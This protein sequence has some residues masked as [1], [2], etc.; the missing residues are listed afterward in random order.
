[1][2]FL[3]LS[4]IPDP[5]ERADFEQVYLDYSKACIN[6]ALRYTGKNQVLAEDALHNAVVKILSKHPE[7]LKDSC[8]KLKASIVLIVRNEAI[9]LMRKE[10]VR[11]HEDLDNYHET[12][13]S[14]EMSLTDIL[15]SNESYEKIKACLAMLDDIYRIV[16]VHKYLYYRQNKEIAAILGISESNVSVRLFRAKRQLQAYLTKEETINEQTSI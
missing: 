7:Y 10:R 12:V 5:Q 4:M 14:E 11:R 1:M 15:E 3:Y 6:E 8:N 9:D 2:L 16:F 13:P